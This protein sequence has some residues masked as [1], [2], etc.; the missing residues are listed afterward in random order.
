M[1]GLMTNSLVIGIF[2]IFFLGLLL[3][4]KKTDPMV[5]CEKWRLKGCIHISGR[6]CKFPVCGALDEFRSSSGD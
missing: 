5:G 2:C 3:Y 6:E 4:L 1:D